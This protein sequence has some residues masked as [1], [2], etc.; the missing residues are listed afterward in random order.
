MHVGLAYRYVSLLF[1]SSV[2]TVIMIHPFIASIQPAG[3]TPSQ[4][5][6]EEKLYVFMLSSII[7]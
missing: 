1:F 5:K 7:Y 3:P 4:R 2:L 6:K